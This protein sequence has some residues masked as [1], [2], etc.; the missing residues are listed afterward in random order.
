[1]NKNVSLNPKDVLQRVLNGELKDRKLRFE[2]AV[3]F[4]NLKKPKNE[5]GGKAN[6]KELAM[7]NIDID[8]Q[9]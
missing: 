8:S 3:K 5:C 9:A 4:N 7:T 2:G 1:M 6:K